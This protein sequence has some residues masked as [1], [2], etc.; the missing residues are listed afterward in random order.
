MHREKELFDALGT[1]IILV[2]MGSVK[3]SES[4]RKNHGLTFKIICD[5]HK[6]LYKVYELFS[7]GLTGIAS[8]KVLVHGMRALVRGHLPGV[9]VGD[10]FQLSGVFIIDRTSTIRYAHYSKDIAGYPPAEELL[11]EAALY[12]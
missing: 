6:H 1:Q 12:A 2:G 4:F 7:A 11:N 5:P 10:I 3:Q 8:P 9:P